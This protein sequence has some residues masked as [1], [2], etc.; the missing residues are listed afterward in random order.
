MYY[1]CC[2]Y[3]YFVCD[4][5]DDVLQR[6]DISIFFFVHLHN[7][8]NNNQ[9]HMKYVSRRFD[10]TCL[11]QGCEKGMMAGKEGKYIILYTFFPI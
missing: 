3:T 11:G 4:M 9:H 8:N 6:V 7:N 1:L 5:Y 2:S 10:T